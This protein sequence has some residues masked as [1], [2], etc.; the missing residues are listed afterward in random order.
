MGISNTKYFSNIIESLKI[1]GG[2]FLGLIFYWFSLRLY[3][4]FTHLELFEGLSISLVFYSFLSGLRF[5]IS[6]I[7]YTNL[8]FFIFLYFKKIRFSKITK[9]LFIALNSC[10]GLMHMA[11]V[12]YFGLVGRRLDRSFL[13][14]AG[15]TKVSSY[16]T[17][18]LE[19]GY[20]FLALF[21][22]TLAMFYLSKVFRFIKMN[23]EE[24]KLKT[25][26]LL[27]PLYFFILACFTFLGIRGGVQR[28]PLAVVH[29]YEFVGGN[30]LAANLSLN[31]AY[32]FIRSKG[33]NPFPDRYRNKKG[34]F[35]TDRDFANTKININKKPKNILF[36]FIESMS[37]YSINMN[38][39]SFVKKIAQE[40][41]KETIFIENH[42]SNGRFSM[43]ALTSVFLGVP[44]FFELFLFK[45]NFAQNK[46]VGLGTV[47][48]E[49]NFN[50]FFIHAAEPGTM[51]FDKITPAVGITDFYALA[52][53]GKDTPEEMKALWGVHDEYMYKKSYPILSEYGASKK[54]FMG[55]LFSVSSH[56]PFNN[57]PGD[58]SARGDK[59]DNYLRTVT[60][61][62]K[63]LDKF[64][65]NIKDE[66]WFKDTLFIVTG[67]HSPP[68]K[69]KW[70]QTAKDKSR[71]PLLLYFPGSNIGEL[72]RAE[73]SQHL[74]LSNTIFDFL[75]IK[76]REWSPYGKSIFDTKA[77][78]LIGYYW[79]K[80]FNF[81]EENC[82]S[83][84]SVIQSGSVTAEPRF[85]GANCTNTVNDKK[86]Y[87]YDSFIKSYVNRLEKNQIYN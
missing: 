5:D 70:L 56:T 10:L 2:L 13:S 38:T 85:K 84:V 62:E 78:N 22:F 34:P 1:S 68:L 76:P 4:F 3:L 25:H 26:F 66:P 31:T 20:M 45:S 65:E 44:S 37:T 18:F 87:E 16:S 7:F 54:P 30:S 83:T 21:V 60:Y 73:Y 35:I 57:T 32:N 14:V 67:D 40:K 33:K 46:W 55:V 19:Y 48:K 61:A 6:T 64:F 58:T 29:A 63:E 77:R 79:D 41:S 11:D 28:K 49:N 23:E 52:G 27:F 53:K 72:P 9:V 42:F 24:R 51:Y 17:F 71:V 80:S 39:K 8:L 36:V 75:Q 69:A 43:D 50:T 86:I 81:V 82:L 15:E 59:V 12:E 47:L 74:D